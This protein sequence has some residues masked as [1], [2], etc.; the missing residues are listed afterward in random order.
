MPFVWDSV[1][2]E[3]INSFY[4]FRFYFSTTFWEHQHCLKN[5]SDARAIFLLRAAEKLEVKLHTGTHH[6][7]PSVFIIKKNMLKIHYWSAGLLQDDLSIIC[8][9]YNISDLKE[10]A[11]WSSPGTYCQL[12]WDKLRQSQSHVKALRCIICILRLSF[13]F[14]LHLDHQQSSLT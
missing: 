5:I 14:F 1:T 7:P 4:L 12:V 13:F 3:F 8:D 6:Y 9:V 11:V 2:L 10:S